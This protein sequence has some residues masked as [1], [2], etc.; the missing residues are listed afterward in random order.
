MSERSY[1]D[2]QREAINWGE[3]PVIVLAGPGSG[4]T[5]VLTERII[6]ILKESEEDSFRILA[7]T[8]TNKAAAEMSE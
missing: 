8:F 4:K 6:R 2:S 5:M 7:L 1:T 3:G